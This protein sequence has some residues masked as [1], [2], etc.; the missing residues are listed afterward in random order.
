M[1]KTTLVVALTTLS[2]TSCS[3]D[4][5]SA[6][7]VS[8]NNT[9]NNPT[10]NTSNNSSNNSSNNATNNTPINNTPALTNAQIFALADPYSKLILEVDFVDGFAPSD[11]DADM[12]GHL[13]GLVD[14]PDG[15]QIVRDQAI[16]SL[17]QDHVWTFDEIKTLFAS[18]LSLELAANETRIHVIFVDGGYTGDTAESTI[19]G[20]AWGTNVVMFEQNILN[21]CAK[22]ILNGKLCGY[23]EQAIWLHEIGHVIGLVNNGAPLTAEH[24]DPDHGHHCSNPDCIMYWAYEGT[25]LVEAL[26]GKL[27]ANEEATIFEFDSDCMADLAA[28]E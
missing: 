1:W 16:A 24:Q 4:A 3:D 7:N 14:K 28:I 6:N 10:N 8:A 27:D 25:A 5:S 15:I 20:L 17:G 11:I 22:P 13:S 21:S 9:V 23:T 19:L 12:V 26:R 2:L 18:H